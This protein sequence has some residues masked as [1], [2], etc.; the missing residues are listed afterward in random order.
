MND[1]HIDYLRIHADKLVHHALVKNKFVNMYIPKFSSYTYQYTL[2]DISDHIGLDV[3][4]MS[5]G[6]PTE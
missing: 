2:F 6:F 5:S 3:R 4:I 1:I